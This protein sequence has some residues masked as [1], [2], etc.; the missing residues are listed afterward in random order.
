MI[1]YFRLQQ[2]QWKQLPEYVQNIWTDGKG[3]SIPIQ[4]LIISVTEVIV[5]ETAASDNIF[6]IRSGTLCFIDVR[7]HAANITNV[8]SRPIPKT[9]TKLCNY[10]TAKGC[11]SLLLHH[12]IILPLRVINFRAFQFRCTSLCRMNGQDF[13]NILCNVYFTVQIYIILHIFFCQLLQS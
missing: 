8:S 2:R 11:V 4:K 6:P 7:L 13:I 1:N 9:K 10:P 5:I 3:L 12:S